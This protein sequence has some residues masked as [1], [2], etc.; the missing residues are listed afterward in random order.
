MNLSLYW[1]VSLSCWL[2]LFDPPVSAQHPEPLAA[3]SGKR[4]GSAHVV[5]VGAEAH[6]CIAIEENKTSLI[7]Q[8]EV[9]ESIKT[10]KAHT[11]LV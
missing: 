1:S 6:P 11:C 2:V 5:F 4:E 3:H 9:C 7:L 8:S 10:Q